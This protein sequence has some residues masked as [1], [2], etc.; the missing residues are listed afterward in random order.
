MGKRKF[1]L[2]PPVKNS[3]RK[4]WGYFPVRIPLK[5]SVSVF[6]VSVP[7]TSLPAKNAHQLMCH[8]S[9]TSTSTITD[10]KTLKEA[11]DQTVTI[12]EGMYV[13]NHRHDR[14]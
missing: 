6:K 14:L 2:S 9:I 10:L 1:R 3:E 12:S 8:S 5:G 13:Y 4:R 11:I 7:L